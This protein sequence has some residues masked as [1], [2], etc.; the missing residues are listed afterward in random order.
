ME[1][2][3]KRWGGQGKWQEGWKE[4]EAGKEEKKDE[5]MEKAWSQKI[6][7]GRRE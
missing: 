3:K 7:R 2:G 6:K 5:N 4:V 1:I